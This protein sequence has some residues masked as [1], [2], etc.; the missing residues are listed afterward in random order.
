MHF[1]LKNAVKLILCSHWIYSISEVKN[2]L[3]FG[4]LFWVI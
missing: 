4:N 1:L 2:I 3:T